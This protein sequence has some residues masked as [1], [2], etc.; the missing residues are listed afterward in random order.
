MRTLKKAM[1]SLTLA[2]WLFAGLFG[3]CNQTAA[4]PVTPAPGGKLPVE[5]TNQGGL[6]TLLGII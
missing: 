2:G 4:G 5:S 3:G 1:L 6:L